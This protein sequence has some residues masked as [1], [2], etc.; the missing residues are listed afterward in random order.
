[1]DERRL[2][3]KVGALAALAVVIAV[4]LVLLLSGVAGGRTFSLFAD[5]GY[6]GGLPSGAIVKIA[7]V[8]VGRVKDVVFR[9]D[10]K[11]EAGRPLPVR[12]AIEIDHT[13]AK[14]LR[15]DASASVGM[16]GALG[17]SYVELLPGT[18]AELLAPGAIIRGIDPPR[19]DV[20]LAR[21]SAV[22]EGAANDEA[23]RE[24]LTE[25]AEFAHTLNTVIANHRGEIVGFLK[26]VS[27]LLDDTHETV[28]ELKVASRHAAQIM[29][30]PEVKDLITNASAITKSA[31]AELPTLLADTR[32]LVSHLEKTAGALTPQDVERVRAVL[33]R[34]EA[35]G[36]DLQKVSSHVDSVLAGVQRGEG[37][38]GKMAKDPQVYD[39]LRTL[40]AELK[41]KPWKLIWKD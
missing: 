33:T 40:L 8:R 17:E 5:F 14:A 6:A 32:S 19:L 22:M 39:D 37:T 3:L 25:V 34:Y 24:F 27:G 10:G 15:A 7:G 30:S 29:S 9:P 11:D 31:K 35:L 38:L 16:Q 28:G 12:L 2:E 13:A 1:M 4:A 20:M 21:I 41:A 26:Q 23:F 18:K 36:G